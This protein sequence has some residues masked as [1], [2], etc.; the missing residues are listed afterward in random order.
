M[1]KEQLTSFL[2]AEAYQREREAAFR[3]APYT[4]SSAAPTLYRSQVASQISDQI[5]YADQAR[6]DSEK[7]AL[8]FEIYR[9]LPCYAL[10]VEFGMH[11]D[12]ASQQAKAQ[13]WAAAKRLLE[14]ENLALAEPVA[15]MLA[16]DFFAFADRC[17]DAWYATTALPT[18]PTGLERVLRISS[19]VP[20]ALKAELYGRLVG[21]RSWHPAI[22]RSL[23]NSAT[24]SFGAIDVAAAAA[25]LAK[26]HVEPSPMYQEL[27]SLLAA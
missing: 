22:L 15:Y 10:L 7:I 17:D 1:E 13:F 26:L 21:D 9:D 19:R 6:S 25:L 2:S 16:V 12:P 14:G 8:T 3:A 5:W 11:Y 24:D 4:G 23:Y 27:R 20:Y 18:T